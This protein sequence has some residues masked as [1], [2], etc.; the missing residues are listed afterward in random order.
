MPRNAKQ[1]AR[2]TKRTNPK[3]P[4]R[5]SAG[6]R[7]FAAFPVLKEIGRIGESVPQSS[8]DELP[9]DLSANVDHYVYGLPK[10]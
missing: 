2:S 8:W 4:N 1:E 6:Q 10:R 9:R 3:S 7:A 5:E